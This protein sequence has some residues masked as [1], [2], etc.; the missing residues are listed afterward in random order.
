MLGRIR[1]KT[2]VTGETHNLENKVPCVPSSLL[3][4]SNRV[5]FFFPFECILI[6][7]HNMSAKESLQPQLSN[8][9]IREPNFRELTNAI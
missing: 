7:Y 8:R 2:I 1:K 9:Y 4:L 5:N 6:T 3:D